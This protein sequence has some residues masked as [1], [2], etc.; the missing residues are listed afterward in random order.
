[1]GCQNP[2]LRNFKLSWYKIIAKKQLWC[3]EQ[4][5]GNYK[6]FQDLVASIVLCPECPPPFLWDEMWFIVNRMQTEWEML[7][8]GFESSWISFALSWSWSLLCIQSMKNQG[9]LCFFLSC[10]GSK[11]LLFRES[12]LVGT[13]KDR[14][15]VSYPHLLEGLKYS[16][17][18]GIVSI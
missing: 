2:Q 6:Q 8:Q 12:F 5:V 17:W 9:V 14:V 13:L 7:Y 3:G 4:E 10:W 15:D 18:R 1:M 16:I 11:F